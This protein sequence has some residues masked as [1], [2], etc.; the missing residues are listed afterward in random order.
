MIMT[1][2]TKTLTEQLAA[3]RAKIDA[4]DAAGRSASTMNRLWALYFKIED[5]LKAVSRGGF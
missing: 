3:Q 1:T 5:G 2:T 4:A